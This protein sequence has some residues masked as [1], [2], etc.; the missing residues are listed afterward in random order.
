MPNG[1]TGQTTVDLEALDEDALGDE[2]EGGDFLHN[3]IVGSF[4][5]VDSMLGLVLNFSL[6]P[7]LLFGGFSTTRGG[8]GF[9]FGLRNNV[10][11][12]G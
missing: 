3:T 11:I 1:D 5:E 2:F 12:S 4:V 6:R 9:C 10:S 7:L 8:C